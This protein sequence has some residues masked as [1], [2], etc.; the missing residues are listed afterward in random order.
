MYTT[1]PVDC[2]HI[3]NTYPIIIDK[4]IHHSP[5]RLLNCSSRV[6]DV[7]VVSSVSLCRWVMIRNIVR[8]RVNASLFSCRVQLWFFLSPFIY[9]FA[10]RVFGIA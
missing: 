3:P 9:C 4:Q 7:S 2:V 8:N 6:S 5:I 10:L 1:L